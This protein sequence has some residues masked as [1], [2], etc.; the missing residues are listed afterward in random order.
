[1]NLLETTVFLALNQNVQFYPPNGQHHRPPQLLPLIR[2]PEAVPADESQIY[3]FG[4]G[5][6]NCKNPSSIS[7]S[8]AVPE[9]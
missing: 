8:V 9:N 2:H 4:D 7:F 5:K 3:I 1:L 6:L